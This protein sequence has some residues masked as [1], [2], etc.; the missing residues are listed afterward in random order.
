MT[1]HS[2]L[3]PEGTDPRTVSLFKR[4]LLAKVGSP[5]TAWARDAFALAC[6]YLCVDQTEK[7]KQCLSVIARFQY[8]GKKHDMWF[9]T[10]A[11]RHGLEALGEEVLPPSQIE[12]Q[13][14]G[15]QRA[16]PEKGMVMTI[17]GAIRNCAPPLL[18]WRYNVSSLA[19]VA[20]FAWYYSYC[21]LEAVGAFHLNELSV[22]YIERLKPVFWGPGN[23]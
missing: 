9:Y 23:P 7:A 19:Q 12:W 21:G 20:A 5:N 18:D 2:F 11:A 15:N 14:I 6:G 8:D 1:S 13:A 16:A 10:A 3:D 17:Q 4:S 22:D